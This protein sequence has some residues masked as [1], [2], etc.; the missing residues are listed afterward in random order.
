MADINFIGT[1]DKPDVFLGDQKHNGSS[2]EESS[3]TNAH[4][5]SI[6]LSDHEEKVLK[7]AYLKL[8]MFFLTTIT[9]IYWLNFLGGSI[10]NEA[11]A[12]HR[13][14]TDFLHSLVGDHLDRAN[15]GNA[16]AA[17]MQTQLRLTNTEYS[18]ALTVT[19]ISFIFAEWPSV[20]FCKKL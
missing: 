17:G 19:Y 5:A 13:C 20:M 1:S 8:D 10:I 9:I 15:I 18:I 14:F 3:T 12:T 11:I 2:M 4:H 7:K 16:R 6:Q